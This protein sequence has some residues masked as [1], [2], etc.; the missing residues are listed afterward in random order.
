MPEGDPM[1]RPVDAPAAAGNSLDEIDTPA[2]LLDLDA[3]QSNMD[4]VHR[5]IRA[6]GLAVRPH[7]KAH[8]CP[9]LARLQLAAGAVGICCQKASEAQVFARAGFTDIL[10]TNQLVGMRKLE[11]V[12]AMAASGVRVGICVDHPLQVAQAATAAQARGCSIDVLIEVDIGHGR[13]GVPD[14]GSALALASLIR[15]AG[16]ALRFAGLHAFRG[17]A[18][19]MRLPQERRDAVQAAV[20]RLR[21]VIAALCADGFSCGTVTGGGTGTYPHESDSSLYTE[22]QPGSYVLM[23]LDY[24]GNQGDAGE[25]PLRHALTVLCTV[26]SVAPGH[27]VLDGGLKAFAVDQGLPRMTRPGWSVK[28]LSDEHAVV[29]PGPDARPLAV[30]DKVQLIPGH[31]DPTVNLHDWMVA[32]RAGRVEQIWP[33]SARGALF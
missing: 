20:V 5:R 26:I 23:D 15:E 2:L 9:P 19:H 21:E 14:A 6:A 3:M 29:V 24:A 7:V 16:S 12:V 25:P 8:K 11:R 10:V 18:Q 33:V 22:V 4:Q 17:S 30:G 32:C 13:C 27:A 1:N 28:S 31:C